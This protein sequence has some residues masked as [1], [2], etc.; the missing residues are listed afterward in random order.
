MRIFNQPKTQTVVRGAIA[1]LFD[2]LTNED[3]DTLE[4]DPV[5]YMLTK[6]GLY[7]SIQRELDNLL[8][9]RLCLLNGEDQDFT[10][11]ETL[12]TM[13]R[14]PYGLQDF[15]DLAMSKDTHVQYMI[16]QIELTIQ[17][18]EPR[19]KNI[20][21]EII[22]R[23]TFNLGFC[24]MVNAQLNVNRCHERVHFPLVIHHI[25]KR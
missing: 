1:P 14:R 25:S 18:Y 12:S 6:Q 9:T 11:S 3:P 7:D 21:V 13:L 24:I 23:D 5:T 16:K 20:K 2:R 17:I 15:S 19:L 10:E 4:E 8:N 22:G